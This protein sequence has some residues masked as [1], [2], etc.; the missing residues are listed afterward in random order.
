MVSV[1]G[2]EGLGDESG[3]AAV[4]HTPQRHAVHLQ[5][6]LTHFQLTTVVSRTPSLIKREREKERIIKK[7]VAL[8]S[9]ISKALN[10]FDLS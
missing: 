8:E 2:L 10:G 9:L 6:H 4:L 7:N 5:D 1:F 3:R